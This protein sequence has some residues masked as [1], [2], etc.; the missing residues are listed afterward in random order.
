MNR[1]LLAGGLAVAAVLAGCAGQSFS[2]GGAEQNGAPNGMD[3]RWVLAAPNAPTCGIQFEG[4]AGA[5]DGKLV[6]EGG[7]PAHFYTGR[8]WTL[9]AGTLTIVDDDNQPLAQLHFAND[10]FEG[11][12]SAGV[13]LTLTLAPP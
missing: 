5:R 1:G 2:F 13:P 10:R 6:P 4:G 11:Q 7:C 3:G 8:R 9:D 12:T